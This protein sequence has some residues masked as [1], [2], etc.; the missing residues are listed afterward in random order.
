MKRTSLKN[1]LVAVAISCSAFLVGC[2]TEAIPAAALNTAKVA[3]AFTKYQTQLTLTE[4][5]IDKH[6][7]EFTE[8]EWQAI[9]QVREQTDELNYQLTR[10]ITGGGEGSNVVTDISR[11][12][13]AVDNLNARYRYAYYMIRPKVVTLSPALQARLIDFHKSLDTLSTAYSALHKG[14]GDATALVVQ[15]LEIIAT[16]SRLFG[17]S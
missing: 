4:N 13:T 17:K 11:F 8:T 12:L 3:G 7:A 2:N 10:L 1:I 14:G 15:T 6:I 16:G 5:V 9:E